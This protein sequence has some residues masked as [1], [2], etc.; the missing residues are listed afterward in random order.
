MTISD[1]QFIAQFEDQSLQEQYF[2]HI[3]H[4]RLAFLYLQ[5]YDFNSACEKTCSGIRKYAESLGATDKFNLTLTMAILKILNDRL[6]QK[7]YDNWQ[8]FIDQNMDVRE[9][10]LSIIL[11]DYSEDLLFSSRAQ[12]E[13]LPPDK[14]FSTN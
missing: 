1:K 12:K 11:E 7:N 5:K 2:N 10:L 9:D 6:N 14:S 3:G 8:T 13:Y 4:L